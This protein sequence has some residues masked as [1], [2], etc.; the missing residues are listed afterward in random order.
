DG[1]RPCEIDGIGG[2]A[3]TGDSLDNED[4]YDLFSYP[5]KSSR[6]TVDI[7]IIDGNLDPKLYG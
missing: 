4:G 3:V 6:K 2:D 7:L 1:P 5:S